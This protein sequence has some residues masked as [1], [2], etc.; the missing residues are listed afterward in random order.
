MHKYIKHLDFTYDFL[1]FTLSLL[2]LIEYFIRKKSTDNIQYNK[3]SIIYYSLLILSFIIL[4]FF[5]NSILY[6]KNI[7]SANYLTVLLILLSPYFYKYRNYKSIMI[8]SGIGY[9]SLTFGIISAIAL[10]DII[11]NFN[12]A[13]QVYKYIGI[14]YISLIIIKYIGL[15][16]ILLSFVELLLNKNL[17]YKYQENF[18]YLTIVGILLYF[19]VFYFVR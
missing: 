16:F 14:T 17:K 18:S 15:F 11:P 9:I 4:T 12:S 10:F 13:E 6:F 2:F 3:F 7:Y 1:L 8:F 5:E 19:I